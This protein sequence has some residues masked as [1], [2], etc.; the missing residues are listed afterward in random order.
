MDA[1]GLQ[2]LREIAIKNTLFEPGRLG[3]AVRRLGFVQADPIRSPAT[4]QD[5]ILRQRVEFYRA[6]DLER[7]YH[8]LEIEED[9][10]YAYGF[11]DR[12]VWSL[13]HPREKTALTKLDKQLIKAVTEAQEIHPRQ[14]ETQFGGD[15]VI[16]AWGGYSKATTK[17]LEELHYAGYFR[18][19]RRERGIRIY[20]PSK[21]SPVAE[22]S[23]QERAAR[24]AHVIVQILQPVPERTLRETL[25]RVKHSLNSAVD[26]SAVLSRCY[27]SGELIKLSEGDVHYILRA[28]CTQ[29]PVDDLPERV[30]FLAPFD[31]LVW[32]RRRFELF[33]SWAYRFEAYTP[34]AKRE[35]GYYALP[36]LWRD[37]VIGWV[38]ASLDAKKK[39]IVEPG[40]VKSRPR[41]KQFKQAFEHEFEQFRNFLGC[42]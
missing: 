42:S 13:L 39:L 4:A 23:A 25:N 38:N 29:A 10:F 28:D 26:F 5:L 9:L 27:K 33:W 16:N 19:V 24:L 12:N 1:K 34:V 30:R 17:A 14:L 7:Q 18:I 35:R 41:D 8:E 2:Q 11:L 40:F 15:R 36:L 32:D 20:A 22:L 37:K 3:E 6:G 31:P 21:L